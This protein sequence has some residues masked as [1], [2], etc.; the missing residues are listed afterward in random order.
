MLG[1]AQ[2]LYPIRSHEDYGFYAGVTPDNRQVLM[3]LLCPNIVVFL[4]NATG[5][6]V[7]T[8]QRRVHFFEGVTPPFD[9]YDGRIPPMIDAWQTEMRLQPGIIKVKKFFSLDLSVVIEDY[10]SH[11]EAILSDPQEGEDAK[12]DIRDSI[13][14]WD[15]EK[16]FVLIWG[17][18][19]WLNNSGEVVSS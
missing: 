13:K 19:Y 17:N 9:I 8:K 18:D 1:V 3:G 16:Q 7:E 12:I 10:P 6:L 14:S 4:F 2:R 5:S 15:K 11:F